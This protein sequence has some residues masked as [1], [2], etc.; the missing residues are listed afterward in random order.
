MAGAQQESRYVEGDKGL[1]GGA[2]QVGLGDFHG[3]LRVTGV[4]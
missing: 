3:T 2:G 4:F 1:R